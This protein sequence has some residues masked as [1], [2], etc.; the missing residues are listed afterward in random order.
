MLD[1]GRRFVARFFSLTLPEGKCYGEVQT[2][3]LEI[4]IMKRFTLPLNIFTRPKRLN[5][6]FKDITETCYFD[7]EV[8]L[9]K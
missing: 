7:N 3:E 9:K 1:S 4:L 2:T 6:K 5:K 8:I